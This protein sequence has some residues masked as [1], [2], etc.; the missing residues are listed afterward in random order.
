MY[1][2]KLLFLQFITQIY[3]EQTT[4]ENT[5]REYSHNLFKT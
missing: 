2:Q 3:S 1:I 5:L 4:E